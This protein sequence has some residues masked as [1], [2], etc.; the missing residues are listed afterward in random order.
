MRDFKALAQIFLP[1]IIP[2]S[3]IRLAPDREPADRHHRVR[4]ER[5]QSLAPIAKCF[6]RL[7]TPRVP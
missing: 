7:K 1:E 5:F 4:F 2:K 3:A 6:L